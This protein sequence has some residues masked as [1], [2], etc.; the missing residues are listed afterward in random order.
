[1]VNRY[2]LPAL[3]AAGIDKIRFHDLRHTNA[4]MRIREGQNVVYIAN[5][6][7]HSTP[8]VTLNIYSHLFETVNQPAAAH[9]EGAL[10]G[11]GHK[12]VTKTKKGVTADSVTP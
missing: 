5:Q 12:I 11:T 3:E 7:G 2:F 8:T 1:M 10:L 4:S 6:L 9:L